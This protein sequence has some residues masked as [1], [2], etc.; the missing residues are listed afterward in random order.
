MI[1]QIQVKKPIF[2]V[3]SVRKVG[4]NGVLQKQ[5]PTSL[6]FCT[7]PIQPCIQNVEIAKPSKKRK[8]VDSDNVNVGLSS[9]STLASSSK[10]QAAREFAKNHAR[11]TITHVTHNNANG[12]ASENI[13]DNHN[14]ENSDQTDFDQSTDGVDSDVDDV[15]SIGLRGEEAVSF[16]AEKRFRPI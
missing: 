8:R 7:L 12:F 15:E 10:K 13:E 5:K 2:A 1:Y 4:T 14:S 16:L 3:S 6:I 9:S 11:K